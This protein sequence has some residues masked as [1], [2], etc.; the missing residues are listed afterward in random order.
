MKNNL[1][2]KL[3][4]DFNNFHYAKK[5]GLAVII[6]ATG[7]VILAENSNL[8]ERSYNISPCIKIYNINYLNLSTFFQNKFF[9]IEHSSLTDSNK[10]RYGL[11]QYQDKSFLG[12]D[13]YNKTQIKNTIRQGFRNK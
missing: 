2:T 1:N 12:T 4:N 10:K 9:D 8:S 3:T 5:A 13:L 11:N 6:L 7:L